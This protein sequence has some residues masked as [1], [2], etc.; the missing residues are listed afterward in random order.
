MFLGRWQWST[1]GAEGGK[2]HG[3][4]AFTVQLKS[5]PG[6]LARLCE[7][8]AARGVNLVL[9]GMSHGDTGTVA[10]IADD[11]AAARTALE[12][13]GMEFSERPAL[14]VRMDNVPGAGAATFRRLANADVNM[15]LL[16]PIRVSNEQFFA[17]ICVD[18]VDAASRALGEQIVSG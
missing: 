17:V 9:C 4:S 13:A 2:E 11:E 5:R 3:M 10:F 8:M 15:E 14:T 16:L 7:A 6:E 1:F 12:R 18:D